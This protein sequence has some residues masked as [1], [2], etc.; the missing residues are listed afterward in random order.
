MAVFNGSVNDIESKKNK[1]N[2]ISTTPSDEKYPS[3]KAVKDYVDSN[4][5]GGGISEDLVDEKIADAIDIWAS[6]YQPES[7][8]DKLSEM[9]FGN[10]DY[11]PNCIAVK[12]YVEGQIGDIEVALDSILAIQNELMGVVQTITFTI[13]AITCTAEAG[14]T[15][16]EF[17]DSEYNIINAEQI[18]ASEWGNDSG[19]M[20]VTFSYYREE[21]DLH[22]GGP[23]VHDD[24][25]G[26]MVK[27]TDTIVPDMNY[28]YM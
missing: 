10:E 15:W 11:Y 13:G 16:A 3:E 5:G 6:E 22:D 18:S 4:S 7:K 19:E 21:E 20:W 24:E 28:Y 25:N 12:N 8:M 14:M 26:T 1:T 27:P 17:I 23:L 9:E 2:S